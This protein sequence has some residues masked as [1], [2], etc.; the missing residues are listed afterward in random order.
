VFALNP[1]LKNP[2]LAVGIILQKLRLQQFG[3]DPWAGH[4]GTNAGNARRFRELRLGSL[5]PQLAD[6]NATLE[7][8]SILTE[9]GPPSAAMLLFLREK[10]GEREVAEGLMALVMLLLWAELAAGGVRNDH[11]GAWMRTGPAARQLRSR[12]RARGSI[13]GR[14]ARG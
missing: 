14:R 11:R 5:Y 8:P 2:T 10:A 9:M 1:F 7:R 6:P 13:S 3:A 12:R 4:I